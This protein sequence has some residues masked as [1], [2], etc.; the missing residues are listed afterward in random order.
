MGPLPPAGGWVRMEIPLSLLRLEETAITRI[1]IAYADG[2]A[3]F[4]HFGKSGTGCIPTVAAAPTIP[5][6][7]TVWVDD[8][9]PAGASLQGF[10]HWD[11]GQAAGGSTS[12]SF[13]YSGPMTYGAQIV[14]L[15]QPVAIGENVVFYMKLNECAPPRELKMRWFGTGGRY[16]LVYWGEPVIGEEGRSINMGPLP[17]AGGWVRME[18]PLSLLRLEQTA[19]TRIDIAYA[20]GQAW[21]D[22]FGKS[23][24]GCIP[25]VG[26]APTIP[27][28]DTVW[29]DDGLPAGASLQNGYNGPMH[30][31]N[32]QA[33]SGSS[34]LTFW[35]GGP[36]TYATQ[37]IGLNQPVASGD[38]VVFYMKLNECAPPR[39]L[40]MRWFGASGYTLLYWGEPVI[41][42]EAR[43]IN[44]GPLP[45]AGGWVRMEIP[46]SLLRLQT[47]ITRIDIAYAD[48]QIWFDHF[49]KNPVLCGATVAPPAIP[50]GDVSWIDD[51]VPSGMSDPPWS[52]A[53]AASGTRSLS[54]TGANAEQGWTI[55]G[56]T[57]PLLTA[58]GD[59]LS[60]YLLTS[61]CA[62]PREI[63]V[64]WFDEA[65]GWR[66]LYLGEPLLGNEEELLARGALPP[67]G[68]WARVDV[69]AA[70]LGLELARITGLKVLTSDGEAWLDSFARTP[71]GAVEVAGHPLSITLDEP[72]PGEFLTASRILVRGSLTAD[73]LDVG[74]TVNGVPALM[75]LGGAEGV[76]QP[77]P[78]V[79]ELPVSP[80]PL[81]LTA[82]ATTAIGGRAVASRYVTIVDPGEAADLTALPQAGLGPLTV[83]FELR[84]PSDAYFYSIDFGDPE[85]PPFQGYS[86]PEPL[87]VT[88][89]NR[90]LKQIKVS[91][92]RA[93]GL[94]LALTTVVW[95]QS[96][97]E[98]DDVLHER[99]RQFTG[100]LSS[101]NIDAAL[102]LMADAETQ[103]RYKD[104]LTTILPS[105]E[106]FAAGI[107]NIAAISIEG[108]VAHYLLIRDE[109]GTPY[110]YHVYFRRDAQGIWKIE[111]F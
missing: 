9:L 14:G 4:D 78:W 56:A 55:Q 41:G 33:A 49:G 102:G 99:W 92:Q 83:A 40:K 23:G 6:G 93:S 11:S 34:S 46:L 31:D 47:A 38:N 104:H 70:A 45:P 8:S 101:R 44:M 12:L 79:A 81:P 2:Q 27:D 25:T 30:W 20:D 74:V 15:N 7:D 67:A 51:S 109:D 87:Q 111:Q 110:G 96:F 68:A 98:V 88:Y 63:Q 37:I 43:S 54:T 32:G 107:A 28:G 108:D 73:T 94:E 5:D 84:V 19:I 17:P 85:V 80:G 36:M 10:L 66:G 86:L 1:D 65:V 60:F 100:A 105:I 97:E 29:L 82:V 39:E 13:T 52:T 90:G 50:T 57:E 91:V 89:A 26:A 72:G 16:T 48:G 77:H 3:W 103:A 95:V 21:F 76:G 18:I 42:E 35:Y 59:T 22:R 71:I 62:K 61:P 58:I 64:Q 69:P 75:D 53:Q 24:T 106:S